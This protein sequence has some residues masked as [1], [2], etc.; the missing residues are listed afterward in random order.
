MTKLTGWRMEYAA[1]PQA[2]LTTKTAAFV[3]AI[4]LASLSNAV[5][6]ANAQTYTVLHT[7]S[8]TDGNQPYAGLT[9]DRA[10]NLYGTTSVGGAGF[11]TVF[12]LSHA[13]SGWTLSNLY[14]FRGGSDGAQPEA[15][16]VFA[17]DGTLYGT[18]TVGGLG[19]GTVFNL[20]PPAAIICGSARCPWTETVLYRFTGGSAGAFPNFGDL[21]FD[22]AGNIYGTTTSGGRGCTAYGGCGVVFELSRSGESWT[23]SVIYAFSGESGDG[24]TPS[25]GVIFDAAGNL[26]GT[27][28]LGGFHYTGSIYKLTRAKSGW[29]ENTLFSFGESNQ[30]SEPAGGLIFDSKGNLYGTTSGGG[31]NGMGTVFELQPSV[32]SWT[33]QVLANVPAEAVDTPT[34]D[35]AGNLYATTGVQILGNVFKVTPGSGGWTYTDLYDFGGDNGADGFFL[36]GGVVL[37]A[38]GNIYGTTVEGGNFNPPCGEGCGVVWEITP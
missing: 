3:F 38:N 30:G 31:N 1:S 35:T 32:S 9:W 24:A 16:V 8:G 33:Y 29:N 7:F 37:D 27:T 2:N 19:Y 11:G 12:E 17:P 10:G 22:S 4:L 26:Y 5:P 13:D 15:R 20:R 36:I 18:T 34:M 23:E 25:S 28:T 21:T 14:S 6:A